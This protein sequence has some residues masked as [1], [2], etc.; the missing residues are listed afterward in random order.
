MIFAKPANYLIYNGRPTTEFDTYVS[1]DGSFSSP[2]RALEVQEIPGRNGDLIFDEGRYKNL[3]ITYE[4]WILCDTKEEFEAKFK[5]LVNHLSSDFG[6]HKLE[7]TYHPDS[8]RMAYFNG[9]LAINEMIELRAGTFTLTFTARPQRYLKSGEIPKTFESGST[10][11]I[12]N[13]TKFYSSPILRI[14]GTGEVKI[15]DTETITIAAAGEG[16]TA[17]DYIDIDCTDMECFHGSDSAN[18]RVSFSS[19]NLLTLK[20]GDNTITLGEGITKI[21]VWGRWWEL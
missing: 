14:Y 3:Q 17:F 21:T 12:Y 10:A 1:G 8:Y 6:Y 11:A 2:E 4:S 20:P 5:D 7:D 9:P 18:S 13:P 16:E 15:N 19:Y